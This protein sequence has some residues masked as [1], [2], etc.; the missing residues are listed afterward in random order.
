[1]NDHLLAITGKAYIQ[2]PLEPDTEYAFTGVITTYG[3]DTR[4]NQDGNASITYKARFSDAV[5]L[6]REN[7]VILGKDRLRAS[8]KLRRAIFAMGFEYDEFMPFLMSKLD[9]LATEF[10]DSRNRE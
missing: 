10:E 7:T 1:M 9:D 2:A 8:Q 5:T 6:I 3:A 4:S